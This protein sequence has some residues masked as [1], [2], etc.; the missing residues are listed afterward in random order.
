MHK[1]TRTPGVCFKVNVITIIVYA[2]EQYVT[3]SKHD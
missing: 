3:D 2:Y 1:L